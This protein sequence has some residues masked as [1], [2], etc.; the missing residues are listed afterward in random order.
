MDATDVLT[1]LLALAKAV[2]PAAGL[3][4]L[5]TSAPKEPLDE[6]SVM[7]LD[8]IRRSPG[9]HGRLLREVLNI[10]GGTLDRCLDNL[11]NAELI[12]PVDVAGRL[13]FYPAGKRPPDGLLFLEVPTTRRIAKNV[14][15]HPE[16]TWNDIA[17]RMG[18]NR[19]RTLAA[20]S[21]L[22]EAGLVT[23]KRK[24]LKAHYSPTAK[25]TEILGQTP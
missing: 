21:E 13:C 10:G 1:R 5:T 8:A 15:A 4:P 24:G 7:V 22:A 17:K 25:L 20:L 18:L 3:L 14:L 2:A 23:V 6:K 9:V 16:S 11:I 19:R 12:E